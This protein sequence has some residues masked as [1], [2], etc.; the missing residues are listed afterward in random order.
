MEPIP[1]SH[2]LQN[3]FVRYCHYYQERH[4]SYRRA[5]YYRLCL[6]LRLGLLGQQATFN[7]M[8]KTSVSDERESS[9]L[10]GFQHA[11][12]HTPLLLRNFLIDMKEI[13]LNK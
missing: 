7:S 8:L 5:E 3:S 6:R 11:H 2:F 12:T 1:R 9:I 10:H 13:T 4:S